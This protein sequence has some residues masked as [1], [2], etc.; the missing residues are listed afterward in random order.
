MGRILLSRKTVPKPKQCKNSLRTPDGVF[1]L[2]SSHQRQT[3]TSTHGSAMQSAARTAKL[4][5]TP[6]AQPAQIRSS[7]SHHHLQ[8]PVWEYS[9]QIAAV[10]PQ[11]LGL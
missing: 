6:V 5:I 11:P 7:P 9:D 8:P 2:G 10:R 1:G 3:A 4:L